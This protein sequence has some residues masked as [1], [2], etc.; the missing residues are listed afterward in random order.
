MAD[1]VLNIHY[2]PNDLRSMVGLEPAF[3][4]EEGKRWGLKGSWTSFL[5]LEQNQVDVV[6]GKDEMEK[7]QPG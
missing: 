7:F 1:S 6:L 2:G 3:L 5:P 4:T